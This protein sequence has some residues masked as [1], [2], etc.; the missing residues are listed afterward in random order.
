MTFSSSSVRTDGRRRINQPKKLP[1]SHRLRRRGQPCWVERLEE[2]TLLAG[3]T[4]TDVANWAAVGPAPNTNGQEVNIPA[5]MGGGPNAV[6]GGI[7]AIAVNPGNAKNVFVGGVNGGVWETTNI[8]ANPVAWVPLT[9]QSS[10]LQISSLQFDPTDA[11]N[12]TIVAGIGNIS[13]LYV[14]LGPMTGLLKTTNGGATWTQL[15]NAPLAAGGLQGEV[16]SAVLPRGNTILVGVRTTGASCCGFT[17]AVNSPQPGLFR[18]IDGGQSFQLISGLNNL[19]NGQVLDV[20]GDPSD[21]NRAYVVVGGATGGIFRTDD[22]GAHWTNVTNLAA[23]TTQLTSST[24][25][26]ARLAVSAAAPNP[27]YLAIADSGQ[28]SGVFWSSNLGVMWTAMDLPLTPDTNSVSS[29]AKQGINPGGQA[30]ANLTIAADPTNPNLVYIAGDRQPDD[31]AGSSPF[32]PNSVGAINYSARIFRGN[33]SIAPTGQPQAVPSPQWTPLTDNGTEPI[34]PG[35][36]PG[37]APHADSRA[38]VIDNGELLYSGDGG[39]FEETSPTTTTGT[40]VSV[41]GAPNGPNN[42]LQVAQFFGISYDSLSNIILGGAQDVGTPQQSASGSMVYQDQTGSDGP[43]TAVDDL[44][45]T[46]QSARYIGGTRFYYN[47]ANSNIGTNIPVVP[48]P[49]GLY[50]PPGG[51][52]GFNNF[53]SVAVSTVAPP[54]GQ[55]ALVV[56]NNGTN[57]AMPGVSGIFDST[58]AGIALTTGAINYTQIPTG[59]GWTGVNELISTRYPAITIGGMLGGMANQNVIYAGSGNQVFLRTAATGPGATLTATAALPAGAGTIQSVA[60][61]PDNWM[62]AYATDGSNVYMTTDAGATGQPSRE[63][64]ATI[65]CTRLPRSMGLE[66]MRALAPS[67]SVKPMASSASCPAIRTSG[68]NSDL[69]SPIRAFGA[70]PTVVSPTASL[71][72]APAAAAP[73]NCKTPTTPSFPPACRRSW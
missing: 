68:R 38:M 49:T 3:V 43:G 13:N 50:S 19:G 4:F 15:G 2:R 1:P 63:T 72:P 9:D 40:W 10:S 64:S 42:G 56:I 18:S 31:G 32:P 28:L 23:I 48:S 24:F 14:N 47:S 26:N 67:S 27:V 29:G 69:T 45:S 62:I 6:T 37:S 20:A 34:G 17:P 16:V 44:T 41:N 25:T 36:D 71:W 53:T 70:S 22:L 46:T 33:T 58:N 35:A 12:Q 61:D 59:A 52:N 57:P 8:T 60:T 7:E 39:I 73:L 11:S 21:A 30:S 66:R 54:S 55:S 51:L 65:M 5:E